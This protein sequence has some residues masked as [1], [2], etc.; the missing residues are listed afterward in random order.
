MVRR[1]RL[2]EETIERGL[3]EGARS[4]AAR[5]LN[6]IHEAARLRGS[7]AEQRPIDRPAQAGR[8]SILDEEVGRAIRDARR[9]GV[10]VRFGKLLDTIRG[11]GD[12]QTS[13]D[14]AL[15]VLVKAAGHSVAIEVDYH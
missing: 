14:Q 4:R 9:S 1:D 10:P 11:R 6:E 7:N 2:L 13:A 8:V 15:Q 3:S 5:R 12:A